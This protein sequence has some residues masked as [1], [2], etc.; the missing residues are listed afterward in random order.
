MHGDAPESINR[1]RLKRAGTPKPIPPMRQEKRKKE[2]LD[3]V[4]LNG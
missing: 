1:Q 2:R 4:S 3:H